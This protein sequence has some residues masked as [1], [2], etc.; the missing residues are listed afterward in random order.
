MYVQ[1]KLSYYLEETF[2]IS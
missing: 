2:I 1:Q